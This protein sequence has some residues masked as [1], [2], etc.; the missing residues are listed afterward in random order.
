MKTSCN[1]Y[2]FR[3]L[4]DVHPV[5]VNIDNRQDQ[6]KFLSFLNLFDFHFPGGLSTSFVYDEIVKKS[7]LSMNYIFIRQF[8]TWSDRL[9]KCDIQENFIVKRG[10]QESCRFIKDA[11]TKN[12]LN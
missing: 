12:V 9:G 5:V 11:W 1:T 2:R 8:L 10:F 4:F 6:K 7:K 3:R